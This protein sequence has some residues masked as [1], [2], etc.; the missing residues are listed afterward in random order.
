MGAGKSTVGPLL[1]ARLGWRFVD[2]DHEIERREGQT[3]AE[4]F[5]SQGEPRFRALE[6]ECTR[7]LARQTE[8]VLA[9]GG[10][11]IA[12][13]GNL[14]S[15]GPGTLT[16]WL[17]VTAEEA[18]ARLGGE[19]ATR[20]LLSAPDPHAAATRLLAQRER[21]YREADVAVP[22]DGRTASAVAREIEIFARA[23]LAERGRQ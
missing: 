11:W 10:G 15:V 1:A 5:A 9:P 16:V 20:P 22:T 14:H 18:L 8:I 2:L 21:L 13:P 4:I 7:V 12:T 19:R 6:T 17:Q 23:R 3:V